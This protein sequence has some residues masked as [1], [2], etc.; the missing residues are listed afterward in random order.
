MLNKGLGTL[1]SDLLEIGHHKGHCTADSPKATAGTGCSVID[2]CTS[3]DEDVQQ[4]RAALGDR[5][6]LRGTGGTSV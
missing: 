1:G 4:S 5:H 6:P 2:D 3:L